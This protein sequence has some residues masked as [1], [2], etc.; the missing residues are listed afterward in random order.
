MP[1]HHDTAAKDGIIRVQSCE[2]L[3]L[4]RGK[5][6]SEYGTSLIIQ[7]SFDPCPIEKIDSFGD[8]R[9]GRSHAQYHVIFQ[10]T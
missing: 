1:A 6:R 5:Q 9:E 3:A 8:C 2:H 7:V 4:L 10:E